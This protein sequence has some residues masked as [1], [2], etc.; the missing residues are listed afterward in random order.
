MLA[1]IA[2]KGILFSRDRSRILLVRRSGDDPT[3]AG[4]WENAGGGVEPGETPEEALVREMREEAGIADV[5]VGRVAYVSMLRGEA[6]CL[7]V[8]YLCQS[9]TETVTLSDEH[10]A[11]VWADREACR[12]MLPP[13]I[14]EDFDRHGI[15]RL[16]S[17][18][19]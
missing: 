9:P 12:A 2:V 10:Q 7:I 1:E 17:E 13:A 4:T 16:F 15:F 11:C 18:S 19:T 8:V 6:P 14:L 3:G 5:A